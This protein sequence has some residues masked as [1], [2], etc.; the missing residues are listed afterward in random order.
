MPEIRTTA[1]NLK[2]SCALAPPPFAALKIAELTGARTPLSVAVGGRTIRADLNTKSLKRAL[3]TLA[4][5]GADSTVLVLQGVL[6]G[7]RLDEAG[8]SAQ[9]RAKAPE[10]VAG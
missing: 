1:R 10:P 5:H 3:V 7:D 9:V 8:L 2:A 4:E 6:V